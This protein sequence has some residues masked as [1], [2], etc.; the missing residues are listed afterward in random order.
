MMRGANEYVYRPKLL[1]HIFIGSRLA[2]LAESG[3]KMTGFDR[4]INYVSMAVFGLLG[5]G[6][7]LLI[8]RRTM[9]RAEELAREAE[10]EAG[11]ALLDSAAR[12]DDLEQGVIGDDLESGRMVHPDELDAAALMDDD[13][14]SL[15]DTEGG[16]GY[17]DSWDDDVAVQ[18][19]GSKPG[20]NGHLNGSINGGKK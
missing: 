19:V 16:D 15:W 1:V 20:V 4:A 8:Y 6:V 17:R 2:L 14:I 5:F 12:D 9:A 18:G 11:D 3:D 13:D 7:G 10:L